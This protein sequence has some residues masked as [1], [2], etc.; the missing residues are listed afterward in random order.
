M[1]RITNASVTANIVPITDNVFPASAV[2]ELDPALFIYDPAY[3][4][5][6]ACKSAITYRVVSGVM[7]AGEGLHP[8]EEGTR[9]AYSG[10]KRTL[11]DGPFTETKEAIGGYWMI[12]VRSRE[13]AIEWAKR[14]PVIGDDTIEV[15]QV[16]EFADFAFVTAYEHSVQPNRERLRKIVRREPDPP[17]RQ[18][19][20]EMMPHR[21]A[22]PG[23][24]PRRRRPHALDQA[25]DHQFLRPQAVPL[26]LGL[27]GFGIDENTALDVAPDGTV[28]VVGAG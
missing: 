3:M 27:G 12:Q 8:P 20:L 26:V 18:I 10:G 1:K 13:E 28:E 15:R 14:C 17:L 22:E 6:A 7:L 2:R 16:Q 11:I 21:P 4:Q 23:I 19:E 9:V 25:A 5:T 24:D